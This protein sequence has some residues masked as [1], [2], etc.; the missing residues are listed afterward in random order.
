MRPLVLAMIAQWV[1][2]VCL[3]VHAHGV[4]KCLEVYLDLIKMNDRN[5]LE[6][7]SAVPTTED[8]P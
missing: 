6:N 7:L 8:K 4:N 3:L 1:V 2:I 5:Q